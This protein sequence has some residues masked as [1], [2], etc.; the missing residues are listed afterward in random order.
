MQNERGVREV[1]PATF[2]QN[3]PKRLTKP[4]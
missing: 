4:I 1:N 3:L 2:I